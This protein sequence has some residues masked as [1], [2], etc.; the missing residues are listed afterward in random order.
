MTGRILNGQ[1]AAALGLVTRCCAVRDENPLD[2]ALRV[3]HEIAT[4]RSP[5]AVAL[6]KELYQKT[7]VAAS[8]EYC[9]TVETELQRK[10]LKTWNQ[11][12]ASGRNFG[13]KVPYFKRKK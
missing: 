2:E 13:I 7:W 11:L 1:E 8:E 10:L 12:A 9:L 3:A 6:A 4:Q 5:D